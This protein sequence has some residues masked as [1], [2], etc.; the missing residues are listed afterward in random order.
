[1]AITKGKFADLVR[2]RSEMIAELKMYRD[3]TFPKAPRPAHEST[4]ATVVEGL[5][6]AIKDLD[7]RIAAAAEADPSLLE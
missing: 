4:H 1:M 2:E 6:L 7:R 5:S 3:G